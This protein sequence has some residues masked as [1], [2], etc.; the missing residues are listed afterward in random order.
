MNGGVQQCVTLI[1]DG[2]KY[3]TDYISVGSDSPELQGK[4]IG[5]ICFYVSST[6]TV[7]R[8]TRQGEGQLGLDCL[9]PDFKPRGA[10]QQSSIIQTEVI[11]CR[12]K[13]A[14][15]KR[16]MLETRRESRAESLSF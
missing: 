15:T 14:A 13:M 4:I 16:G 3:T 7:T 12:I 6:V 1:L 10:G 5:T 11:F 2:F 8:L 9:L